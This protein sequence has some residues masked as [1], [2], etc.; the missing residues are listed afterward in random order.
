MDALHELDIASELLHNLK[1]FKDKDTDSETK[2]LNYFQPFSKSSPSRKYLSSF[3][4]SYGHNPSF[5]QLYLSGTCLPT[6]QTSE[7]RYQ[8]HVQLQEL[9]STMELFM[10]KLVQQVLF[11]KE[12][13]G[14]W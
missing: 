8:S 13:Y 12:R 10:Q 6:L 4:I 9:L 1:Q 7:Q 5:T 14:E 2:F 11:Y 3:L